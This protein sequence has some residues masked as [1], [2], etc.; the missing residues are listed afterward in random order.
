MSTGCRSWLELAGAD[1]S[2]EGPEAGRGAPRPAASPRPGVA[3][4]SA[5]GGRAITSTERVSLRGS[6]MH[7]ASPRA[8]GAHC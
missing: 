5:G 6:G 1:W 7:P 8:L 4:L 2:P 3:V